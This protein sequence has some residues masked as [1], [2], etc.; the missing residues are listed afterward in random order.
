MKRLLTLFA[1]VVTVHFAAYSQYNTERLLDV[2]ATALD[3]RDYVVVI[4][5]FQQAL[6]I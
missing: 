6:F 3:N 2:S 1:I 4:H 5:H